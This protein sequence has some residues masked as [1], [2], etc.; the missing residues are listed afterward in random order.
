MRKEKRKDGAFYNKLLEAHK[1]INE[2][3]KLNDTKEEYPNWYFLYEGIIGHYIQLKNEIKFI[4]I[5][6]KELRSQIKQLRE[7]YM[8]LIERNKT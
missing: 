5:E 8:D 3:I 7:K 6:N 4:K 2:V 1:T